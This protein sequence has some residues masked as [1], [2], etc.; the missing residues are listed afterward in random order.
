MA[1]KCQQLRRS[2]ASNLTLPSAAR[3]HRP[4]N[5]WRRSL[6]GVAACFIL[7]QLGNVT[8]GGQAAAQD[9]PAVEDSIGSK[10][11][12]GQLDAALDEARRA[13]SQFPRSTAIRQ[14]LGATLFKKGLNEE[15]R[16]AFRQA[17]VL[18]P[19]SPENYFDLAL[20]DLSEN[21]YRDAVAPLE[22]FVRLD[23]KKAQ[24]HLLLGRAYHNLNQTAPAIDEFKQA[25]A[26][27]PRLP[28]AH[29]HLGYAYQSQGDRKAALEEFEKEMKDNPSFYDSYWLAG[30]IELDQA[31]FAAAEKFF[32]NGIQV[33]PQA[34][35]AHYGLGRVLL[36][37]KRFPEA[38]AE[39][40]KALAANSGHVETH[41]AL[42]RV[43]HQMGRPEDARREFELCARINAQTQKSQ[44]GIAG[45][46]P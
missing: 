43:Y 32:V 16:V 1:A 44:S 15:A 45:Q 41:Y 2:E 27:E 34:Y 18:D 19:S 42:A 29:Y 22:S 46:H 21:R 5:R 6:A 11:R 37:E 28:L 35:Q 25:I 30:D 9:E 39:L 8:F 40:N 38:E 7:I 14:L 31:N 23:P 36:A 13:V 26:L 10:I 17:I 4:V 33:K 24:G 3:Y 20:V 12:A